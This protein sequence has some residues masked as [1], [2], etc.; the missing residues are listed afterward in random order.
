MRYQFLTVTAPSQLLITAIFYVTKLLLVTI[1]SNQIH[2][3]SVIPLQLI[4]SMSLS[5]S[6]PVLHVPWHVPCPCQCPLSTVQCPLSTVRCPLSTVHCPFPTLHSLLFIVHCVTFLCTLFTVRCPLS[7]FHCATAFQQVMY[8][9][10]GNLLINFICKSSATVA[11]YLLF[12][13]NVVVTNYYEKQR[14]T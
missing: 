13:C 11:S 8:R 12:K 5:A 6:L 3:G 7:T 10:T 9:I 1:E 2:E 14:V 4:I